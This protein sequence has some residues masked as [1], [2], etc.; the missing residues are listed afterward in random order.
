MPRKTIAGLE[1]EIAAFN[2]T[3]GELRKANLDLRARTNDHLLL[4]ETFVKL[5]EICCMLPRRSR[6]FIRMR[7]SEIEI[8]ELPPSW[9][10]WI[11]DA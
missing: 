10:S 5:G 8:E 2:S 9:K 4:S 11:K 3:I 7:L 6:H 1:T